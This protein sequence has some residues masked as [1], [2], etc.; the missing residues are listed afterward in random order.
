MG[1]YVSGFL[2]SL[3]LTFAGS[4]NEGFLIPGVF[5][6]WGFDVE[7]FLRLWVLKLRGSMFMGSYIQGLLHRCFSYMLESSLYIW[8]IN[9]KHN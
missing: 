3:V 9:L 2:R 4:Y 5:T 7:G 6:L 8:E 1:S